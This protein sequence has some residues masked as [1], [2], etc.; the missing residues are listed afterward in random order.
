[1]SVVPFRGDAISGS[2]Y[3]SIR[4]DYSARLL[5]PNGVC[6][7][8][9]ESYAELIQRHGIVNFVFSYTSGTFHALDVRGEE[10]ARGETIRELLDSL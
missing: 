7:R 3:D 4:D 9:G 10:L 8:T 1:M 6:K 5:T 2:D